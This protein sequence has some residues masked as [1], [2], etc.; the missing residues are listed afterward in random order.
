MTDDILSPSDDLT[1]ALL[2]TGFD[3]GADDRDATVVRLHGELDIATAPE[4][5]RTLNGALDAR[6]STI[7]VDASELSFLDSTGIRVLVMGFQRAAKQS[8]SFILRSPQAG[9]LRTLKLTGVD[10]LIVIE[11][12]PTT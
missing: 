5:A 9:V 11:P 6:P 2:H 10:G 3:A 4:L 12:D 8:C 7:I 1:S